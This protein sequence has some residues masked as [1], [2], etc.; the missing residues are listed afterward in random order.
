MRA[1]RYSTR[2]NRYMKFS[3]GELGTVSGRPMSMRAS[4]ENSRPLLTMRYVAP[5]V[6]PRGTT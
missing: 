5:G 4:A 6:R 2:S 1:S 3:Y